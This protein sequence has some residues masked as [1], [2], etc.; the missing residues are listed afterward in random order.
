MP[1]FAPTTESKLH[2]LRCLP[3]GQWQQQWLPLQEKKRS[4]TTG[5]LLGLLQALAWGPQERALC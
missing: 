4:L 2:R 1:S 5:G 3:G